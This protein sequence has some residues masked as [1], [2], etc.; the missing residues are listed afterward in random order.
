[1]LIPLIPIQGDGLELAQAVAPLLA[2]AEL[3]GARVG[4]VGGAASL[5][6]AEGGLLVIDAGFP[7]EYQSA[8]AGDRPS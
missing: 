4:V 3:A 7:Q 8:R 2:A 5:F 6:V 1:M